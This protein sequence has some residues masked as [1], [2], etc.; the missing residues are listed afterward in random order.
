MVKIILT[1]HAKYRLLERGIDTHQ[2]KK[3]IKN[4]SIVKINSDGTIV[5][6]GLSDGG[7]F[8]EVVYF[9]NGNNLVIKTA[10]YEG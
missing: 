9:K 5:V 1:N 4:G 6:K 2:V 10:Y 8:I 3:I 7:K